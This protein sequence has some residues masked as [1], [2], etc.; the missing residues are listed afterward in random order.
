MIPTNK[1]AMGKGTNRVK[2]GIITVE[3]PKPV[4]VPI[5]AAT[6]VNTH[7][8]INCIISGRP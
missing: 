1:S 7:N 6:R 2:T 5:A 4:A 8:D 3:V